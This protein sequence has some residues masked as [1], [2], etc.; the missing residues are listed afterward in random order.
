[1]GDFAVKFR[2]RSKVDAFNWALV[3]VY[4]AAQPELKPK[5]LADL[6]RICGS[7]QL[8]ILVG[9]DFNIIRRRE[10]KNNVNFDGR[11]SFMFNTIIE[12]LDLREI[13]LSGRKFTWANSLPNPTYEKLDRVLASV[14]WEQKFPLVTVQALS[15]GFSDHTPLFVDSG[16]P[17][18]VGNKNTFSFEMA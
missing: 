12:S 13:E 18:H 4:G 2:V 17:N 15:R 16:E 7:E 5:F 8:P 3:A 9:G 11:W 6:V 1:M 14:E 10:E